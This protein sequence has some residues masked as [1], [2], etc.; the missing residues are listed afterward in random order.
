MSGE[1]IQKAFK[2]L[3]QNIAD[4][5]ADK[6]LL[7]AQADAAKVCMDEYIA[8][9]GGAAGITGSNVTAYTAA[10]TAAEA[11]VTDR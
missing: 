1:E 11:G 10:E 7:Q 8:A 5:Q 3:E 6:V 2:A 4:L 9:A